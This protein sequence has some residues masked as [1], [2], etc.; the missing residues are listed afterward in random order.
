MA[1]AFGDEC[2]EVEGHIF[3]DNILVAR[4]VLVA[5][6][7]IYLGLPFAEKLRVK[8]FAGFFQA[9]EPGKVVD[10]GA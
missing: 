7:A 2:A 4:D 8:I 1:G 6:F 10:S 9:G 5:K 3:A